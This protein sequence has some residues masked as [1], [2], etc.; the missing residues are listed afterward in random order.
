[1]DDLS[2]MKHGSSVDGQITALNSASPTRH[3]EYFTSDDSSKDDGVFVESNRPQLRHTLSSPPSLPASGS[4]QKSRHHKLSNGGSGGIGLR[5]SSSKTSMASISEDEV[6][7]ILDSMGDSDILS[8]M[9]PCD[10]DECLLQEP[11]T[12]NGSVSRQKPLKRRG[13]AAERCLR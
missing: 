4:D 5:S 13:D 8:A 9:P 2:K 11:Q 1:M 10:C 12:V 7:S 3:P 6:L